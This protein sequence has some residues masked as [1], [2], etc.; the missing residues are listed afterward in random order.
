MTQTLP[1]TTARAKLTQLVDKA[2][3]TWNEYIITVKGLPA[4][5][6][7]SAAQYESW[8][9][10]N[11]IMADKKLLKAIKQGEADLAAGRMY[12][13][14]DVKKELGWDTK[15]YV[16]AKTHRTGKKRA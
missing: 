15:K 11:E 3:K 12:N 14:E 8:Q 1:I 6:L 4:A 16:S 9:E 13:W 10:T 7:I 5:V 2:N